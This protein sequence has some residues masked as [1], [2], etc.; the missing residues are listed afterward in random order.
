MA[1]NSVRNSSAFKTTEMTVI[2]YLYYLNKLGKGYSAI[3]SHK[4]MLTQTLPFFGNAWCNNGGCVLISRFM[5]GVFYSTP[6]KPR[7]TVTWDVSSVLRYLSSLYPLEN[8]S[9]KLLTFK[10]V[11]LIALATA[12][13][14]QTLVALDIGFMV[15]ENFAFKF[16]FP[17]F[18]KNSRQGHDFLLKVEHFH[19]EELCPFHT[20]IRYINVT[21]KHRKSDKLF[22]SYVT[23]KSVTTST[24]ARWLKCV[25]NLSGIDTDKFKAHSYRG[26]SVSKAYNKGCSL[27][28][29]LSTADWSSECIFRK[30]YYRQPVRDNVSYTEAVLNN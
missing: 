26:A 4:S 7:Y 3:N 18:L 17:Q 25:L 6:P 30:F 10:T 16:M 24:V 29:I 13:R 15:K 28:R 9:L 2:Q 27:K 12:P 5:K 23:F 8:L 22:I 14:A 11:A 1:W 21:K 19:K 20:L